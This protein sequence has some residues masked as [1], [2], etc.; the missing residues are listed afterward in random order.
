MSEA[1]L[2]FEKTI[3]HLDGHEVKIRREGI[4]SHGAVMTVSDAK[5]IP[6]LVSM[7]LA[8]LWRGMGESEFG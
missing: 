1:L 8:G 5:S 7:T 6:C 2:G 4:T 3:R